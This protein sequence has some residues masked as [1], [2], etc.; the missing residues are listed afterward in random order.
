MAVL[1]SCSSGHA[2]MAGRNTF[3]KQALP[4][5]LLVTVLALY[6][7]YNGVKYNISILLVCVFL[8]T[9]SIFVLEGCII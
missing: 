7:H 1:G 2:L 6:V 4:L 5:N 3:L 9:E 8:N